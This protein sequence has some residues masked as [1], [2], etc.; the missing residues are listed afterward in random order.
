MLW[1]GRRRW[2]GS[3]RRQWQGQ[4]Q[5]ARVEA[6]S[7]GQ[8]QRQRGWGMTDGLG[9]PWTTSVLGVLLD[10][11][12]C[13]ASLPDSG[14]RVLQKFLRALETVLEGAWR[15]FAGKE[16]REM[17]SPRG[18][19]VEGE[20]GARQKIFL[21]P[22]A[23]D[24]NIPGSKLA[25]LLIKRKSGESIANLFRKHEQPKSNSQ[26]LRNS[27]VLRDQ[28]IKGQVERPWGRQTTRNP[29]KSPT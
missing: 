22:S 10:E 1:D 29:T 14:S 21:A 19:R 25:D 13:A 26:W 3:G 12:H 15:A 17:V 7:R 24:N 5:R 18:R 11:T 2:V 9:K 4:G 8:R 23:P 27:Q 28:G 16:I 20:G 6:N